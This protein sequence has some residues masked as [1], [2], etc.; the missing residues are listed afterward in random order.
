MLK[1]VKA[2]THIAIFAA[3]YTVLTVFISPISYGSIQCRISDFMLFLCLSNKKNAIGYALGGAIANLFSPLGLIDIA[4]GLIANAIIGFAA[5]KT[6]NIPIT[7]VVTQFVTALLVG[8]ELNIV[9]NAPFI[10]SALYVFIGQTIVLIV[11]TVIYKL[12]IKNEY[13]KKFMTG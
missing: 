9:Y 6:N 2:L 7:F 11:G 1:N 5:Y 12:L 13:F 8:G 3:I 10:I 4:V